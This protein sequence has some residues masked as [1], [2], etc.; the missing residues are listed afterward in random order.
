M[1]V[2]H[3]EGIAFS[4]VDEGAVAQTVVGI[5]NIDGIPGERELSE[6]TAIGDGGRKFINGL[7]N[8]S[9]TV[10]GVWDDTADTGGPDVFAALLHHTS[11]TAVLFGPEG[12]TTGDVQYSFNA[13]VRRYAETA[14][15]GDAVVWRAELQI[16]GQVTVGTY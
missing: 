6:V 9:F 8:G 12:S 14:R 2:V 10:E 15:V 16:D 5:T 13:W 1:T 7:E 4:I 3:S 11:A